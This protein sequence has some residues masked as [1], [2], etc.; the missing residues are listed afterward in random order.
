MRLQ[1]AKH[2]Y[3]N[4]EEKST[5]KFIFT[6]SFHFSHVISLNPQQNPVQ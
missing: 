1:N 2:I 5:G 4:L 6:N 3:I